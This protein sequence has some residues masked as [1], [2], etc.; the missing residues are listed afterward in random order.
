[1]KI[2][3][4]LRELMPSGPSKIAVMSAREVKKMNIE[5]ELL[6]YAR[7]PYNYKYEDLLKKVAVRYFDNGFLH[8]LA[9]IFSRLTVIFLPAGRGRESKVDISTI[10]LAPLLLSKNNYD[11]LVFSDQLAGISGLIANFLKKIPY[12]TYVHEIL[13]SSIKLGIHPFSRKHR[14]LGWF[15]YAFVYCMEKEVL[16]KSEKVFFNSKETMDR[17]VHFFPFVK[18]K[19]IVL[20]PGCMPIKRLPLKRKGFILAV[21]RWDAGRYPSFLL[22]LAKMSKAKFVIAGSWTPPSFS[23]RFLKEVR[24]KGLEERVKVLADLNEAKLKELYLNAS[25][26]VQWTAEGFSMG[27]LEA[28]AHGLVVLVSNLAGASEI[29]SDRVD[30]FI[31][32]GQ[33]NMYEHLWGVTA[34]AELMKPSEYAKIINALMGRIDA[35]KTMGER[36]WETSKKY[37]WEMYVQRL[38]QAITCKI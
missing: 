17:A 30:G 8:F 6:V 24:R 13:F 31:I 15:F 7:G 34:P 9:E 10:L 3:F 36:A 32:K 4:V 35:L 11:V 16:W 22:D 21:S 2:G 26:Y 18:R 37:S 1:M 28:M 12:F 14:V 5:S 38:I 33:R 20:Y 25:M 19:G 23:K 29:V 27:V